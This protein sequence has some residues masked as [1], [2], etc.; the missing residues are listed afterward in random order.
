MDKTHRSAGSTKS[1]CH[2]IV[3]PDAVAAWRGYVAESNV[4]DL[5]KL[6]KQGWAIAN[7]LV[8]PMGEPVH[9]VR[10]RLRRDRRLET[11]KALV[12]WDGQKRT[13]TL[14]RPKSLSLAP[15]TAKV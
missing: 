5:D 10:Q 11:R 8:E 6:R 14:F 7:D 4:E 3:I 13:M 1:H 9:V 2:Q 12:F 15:K